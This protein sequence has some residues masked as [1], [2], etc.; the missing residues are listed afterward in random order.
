MIDLIC[1]LIFLPFTLMTWMFKFMGYFMYAMIMCLVWFIQI[2]INIVKFIVSL[3]SKKNYRPRYVKLSSINDFKDSNKKIMCEKKYGEKSKFDEEADL[4]GL[5]EDDIR[6]AKE[7]RM[8]PADYVEA[9][10]RDDDVLDTD[11]WE[12]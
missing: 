8:S 9:E 5:S 10:E 4:W 12:N 3:F 6:I 7:E 11:E 1:R 2:I